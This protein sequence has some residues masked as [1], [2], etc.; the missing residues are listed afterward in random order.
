MGRVFVQVCAPLAMVLTMSLAA[1]SKSDLNLP[2]APTSAAPN[3]AP[4]GSVAGA[5]I[6]GTVRTSASSLAGTNSVSIRP[7]GI[8]L[9]VSIVGTP[10]KTT[11]DSSGHFTLSNVPSGDLTLAFTG[12]GVD[13]R[14]TIA[15]VHN[16]DQIRIG[17]TVNGNAADLDENDHETENNEAEVDGRVA[18]TNCAVN[19]QTIV[20]GTMTPTTVNIQNARIRHDGNTLTCA[21]IQV[22]DRVEAHGTKNGATLVAT[23]VNVETDHG[24]QPPP[25]GGDDDDEEAEV[26]GTVAGA[27]GGHACP[28]FTFTVGSMTVTTT[29]ATQFEDTTCAGVING[30]TVEA[31]GTRT[32]PA[33][34]TAKKV[35]KK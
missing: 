5:T 11:V 30:I 17:V 24:T 35:E 15:A 12:S 3:P 29:A 19:P 1:C 8:A 13:A 25:G 6:S 16:N 21:Q 33:A 9:M 7:A 22:N 18:S 34:I 28:A 14:I 27:A 10:I 4:A 26:K 32:G 23:D 31:E 2:G 20:V